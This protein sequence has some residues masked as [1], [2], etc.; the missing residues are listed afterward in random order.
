MRSIGLVAVVAM[1]SALGAQTLPKPPVAAAHPFVWKDPSG[2]VR[3]DDYAWLRDDTRK[4]PEML[5]YLAAENGYADA[6]LASTRPLQDRLYGEIVGRIKQDDT[7]VPYRKHGYWYYNRYE[8]GADYPIEARRKGDMKAPEEV[9]LDEPRMAAGSSFF[10][11]GDQAVSPDNTRLTWAEDRVGRRQYV[12]KV[13]TIADG[14][15]LADSIPNIDPNIVWADDNRTLFYIQKDPTTLLGNRVRRH[16]LGTPASADTLVYAERDDTYYM[17]IGR[18][19]DDRFICIAVQSTVS[20]EQRCTPADSPGTFTVLAPREREFRYE[21]DHIGDHWVIRTNLQAPNYKLV[22]VKDADVARGR[23]AWRD[24]V[25][26]SADTFVESFK[27][28]DDFLAI[29][30]R[31]GGNK[32]LRILSNDGRSAP[33]A[34]DEPAYTMA[35]GTNEEPASP[36]VR[37][38][39][40]SLAT[41]QTTYETNVRTGERRTLKVQPTPGYDQAS[42][43]TE[44]VWATARNGA[45]VPVSLFYRRGLAKDGRAAL[46]QTAYGSYGV[47][48]DPAWS[49]YAVSLADRGMVYAIAHIR[50]GQEMGRAWY[51]AGHLMN[52]RNSFTDFIDVTRFLVAQRYVAPGRVAA[53]GGSAGGLLMGAVAN[54]APADYRVIIAQ[55]PF[56]DVVTTMLDASIPLTTGEYDEWG[57][58]AQKAAHDYMLSYSPYDNVRAQ[59]YPALFVGTGLWDSQ[60][61][62]YEP[63]K[64]VAKLRATKTD[65]NPLVFRVN[66]EAGHGGKSGRLQRYHQQAEYLAFAIAQ[67]GA[68]R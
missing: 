7:S 27:P 9:L 3:A 55:V 56:V 66:M 1:A 2:G 26:V 10:M 12:L 68:D 51:D 58:P 19:T 39:Y 37:Y 18:T 64:W 8:T 46:F 31:A 43:V 35:I 36:W 47:S 25:P 5:A 11:V 54:M 52:K 28:F 23:A 61:Q 41:P 22:T 32:R 42:Y 63:T 17:Q 16:V 13:K 21:A 62:Y 50:G 33:V 40:G 24:L 60:V 67:L 53:F 29:E 65:A 30:E 59:A 34:A 15:L 20:N 49:N 38:V 45:R 57:N 6:L 48:S 14:R 4:N 44:R